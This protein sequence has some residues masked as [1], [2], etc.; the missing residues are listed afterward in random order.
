MC[1]DQK[2]F[3]EIFLQ[4]NDSCAKCDAYAVEVKI[5]EYVKEKKS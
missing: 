5:N 2:N 4:M 1:T 3:S